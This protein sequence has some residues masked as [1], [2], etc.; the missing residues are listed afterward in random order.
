MIKPA[1]VIL[2][3]GRASRL[4]GG[5]KGLRL[6]GGE[7]LLDRILAR[8]GTD[9]IAPLPHRGRGRDPRER[10]GEGGAAREIDGADAPHPHPARYRS[11]PS[12]AVQ[13]KGYSIAINANG[14]PARFARFGLPVLPDPIADQPGP[15][16]GVLAAMEWAGQGLVATVPGDAPFIPRDLVA[17]LAAA[18]EADGADIAVA[19]SAGR[20]HPVVALW[21]ANLAA[22]LRRAIVE[23]GLRKVER[24]I[25]RHSSVRVEFPV[26]PVDPFFNVNR[27]EDLA[28]AERLCR[29]YPVL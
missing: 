11:P 26:E 6:L 10:E 8:L 23:E 20:V 15:L 2:A 17:R 5:D 9:D 12:P 21:S 24:W 7:T 22:E 28:E 4:G 27:L 13:E 14:D 1:I 29:L 25:D 18:R 3:G 19:A 16:A